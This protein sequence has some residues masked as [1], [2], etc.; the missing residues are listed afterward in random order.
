M[1]TLLALILIT[2]A[3]PAVAFAQDAAPPEKPTKLTADFGFIQTDGNSEVTTLSGNDK[4]EHKSGRWLFTQ[5]AI[6]V[7]GE[8]DGVESA[9]R[10]GF[11]LRGDRA[12]SERLSVFGLAEWNRNTFAGIS[13]QFDEGVGMAYKLITPRPH[14]LDLEAGAGLEQRRP[15]IGPEDNFATARTG[16]GYA[17]DFSEKSQFSARGAYIFNLEDGEDGQ[18]EARFGLTAPLAGHLAMK[19][20]YDLLYRNKPLPGFEKVDT[21]FGVGVQAVF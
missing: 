4:L 7:W 8:T 14:T 17:Y 11:R 1:R 15:T 12:L 19:V 18:G 16:L 13:R 2:L 6:A 21:T 3:L 5:E 10:Y 20:S 9:G